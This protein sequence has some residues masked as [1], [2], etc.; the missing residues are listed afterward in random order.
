MRRLLLREAKDR[1]LLVIVEDLHWIDSETQ[2]FLDDFVERV[3]HVRVLLLVSH[4]PEYRHAWAGR[5]GYTERRLEP[6]TPEG[7]GSYSKRSSDATARW[8]GSRSGWPRSPSAT[9]SSSR[10]ACGP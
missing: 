7:A 6:L 9:R 10:R 4:R 1:P 5:T 8:I 2:A 3:S